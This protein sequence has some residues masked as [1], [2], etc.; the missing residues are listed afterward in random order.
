M[1][2]I[3]DAELYTGVDGAR[4]TGRAKSP[5]GDK[6]PGERSGSSV[7]DGGGYAGR[8]GATGTFGATGA[9]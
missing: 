8:P 2:R 7:G 4:R 1:L 6:T 5:D 9:T 3:R